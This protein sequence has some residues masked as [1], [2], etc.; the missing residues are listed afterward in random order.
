MIGP[1]MSTENTDTAVG[2]ALDLLSEDFAD[3]AL[4]EIKE[5][6][7][8][9]R[10]A[11]LMSANGQEFRAVVLGFGSSYPMEDDEEHT[12]MPGTL[13]IPGVSCKMCR[14]VDVAILRVLPTEANA[15][16]MYLVAPMGKSRV[17]GENQRI[18]T[19]W[20]TDALRVM[21]N[22]YVKGKDGRSRK[23]PIPNAIAFRRAAKVDAGI[24]AVCE[25]F[26]AAIPDPDPLGEDEE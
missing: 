3:F 21:E 9:E 2:A 13:P 19:A 23:L 14:W 15:E 10:T 24:R 20:T 12:H 22:L 7:F 4:D 17:P 11:A 26:D 8:T 1:N 5:A 18:R 25:E 16:G 6:T